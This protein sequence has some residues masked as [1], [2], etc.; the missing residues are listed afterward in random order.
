MKTLIAIAAACIAVPA[1]AQPQP[2][3]GEPTVA[4]PAQKGGAP[5]VKRETRY[6]AMTEHV[7]SRIQRRECRTRAH[8]LRY[9]FDPLD[10][11]PK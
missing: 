3:T 4:A 5:A 10:H 8:W 7:G 1:V 2:A 11:L 6:C 9:G